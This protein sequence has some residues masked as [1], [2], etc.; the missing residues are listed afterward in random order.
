MEKIIKQTRTSADKTRA[1]VLKAAEKLFAKKGFAG[2]SI[3]EIAKQ[4]KINQSL[5]YHHFDS[6]DGLWKA[7]RQAIS[8]RYNEIYSLT[9]CSVKLGLKA[10]LRRAVN[11]KFN[12]LKDNPT[13]LRI[14]SWQRLVCKQPEPLCKK[15]A[16]RAKLSE[17][18]TL[19][20][21]KGEMRSK[22]DVDMVMFM[23]G[24]MV[25][26]AFYLSDMDQ[27]C[28]LAFVVESLYQSFKK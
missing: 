3:S 8:E 27:D 1:S 16:Y 19:L 18:F 26:E 10:L 6:K 23:V 7:V 11:D 21:Q 9:P 20:Q 12:F 15:S 4:A 22:V 2:A 24:S 28:Y 25:H 13:V 17:A 14:V 5:I